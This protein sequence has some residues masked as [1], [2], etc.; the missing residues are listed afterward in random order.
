MAKEVPERRGKP[1]SPADLLSHDCIRYRFHRSG[2][3]APW[4][5]HDVGDPHTVD[6]SGGLIVSDHPTLYQMI[7]DGLGLGYVFRDGPPEALRRTGLASVLTDHL[8]PIPGLYLYYPREYRSM[9]PLRLFIDHMRGAFRRDDPDA[10][11]AEIPRHPASP[12][13]QSSKA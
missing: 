13:P 1:Q 8:L 11:P 12:V 6:V 4:V 10:L 9:L 7:A 3:L 5:F 2:R